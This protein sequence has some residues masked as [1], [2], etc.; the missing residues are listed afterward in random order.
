MIE[1]VSLQQKIVHIHIIVYF[2]TMPPT[3]VIEESHHDVVDVIEDGNNVVKE[4]SSRVHVVCQRVAS[5]FQRDAE[6]S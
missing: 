4:E 3:S 2:F 6:V 5:L 1:E